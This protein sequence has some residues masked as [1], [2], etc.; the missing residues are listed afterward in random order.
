M[1]HLWIQT[2]F[3]HFPNFLS[4]SIGSHH[5]H[6]QF[7]PTRKRSKSFTS[8][9]GTAVVREVGNLPFAVPSVKDYKKVGNH[10]ESISR[11]LTC[12]IFHP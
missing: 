10:V 4:R 8:L 6:T 11:L 1:N 3:T 2:L 7:V 9:E 12:Q 5:A